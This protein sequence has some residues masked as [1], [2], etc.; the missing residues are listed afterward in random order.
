MI[1]YIFLVLHLL[2]FSMPALSIPAAPIAHTLVQPDGVTFSARQWGNKWLHGW[3][4][5]NGHTIVQ[6]KTSKYWYYAI[7]VP[8]GSLGQSKERADKIPS[9]VILPRLRP[10]K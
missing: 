7:P 3:E 6:D 8:D 2:V 1:R 4:T 5:M 9:Q 10:R